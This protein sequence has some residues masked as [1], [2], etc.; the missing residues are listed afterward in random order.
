M[1]EP[2]DKAPTFDS[3]DLCD[4]FV[5][6]KIIHLITDNLDAFGVLEDRCNVSEID[7]FNWPVGDDSQI[8]Y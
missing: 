5:L 4:A 6:I 3:N 8:V 7:P 1:A 2:H